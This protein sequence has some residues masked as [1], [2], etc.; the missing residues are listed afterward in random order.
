MK[1]IPKRSYLWHD[2]VEL[3]DLFHENTYTSLRH[4]KMPYLIDSII[5]KHK[6]NTIPI[7]VIRRRASSTFFH[8]HFTTNRLEII[9]VSITS[10]AD[11]TILYSFDFFGSACIEVIV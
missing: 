9:I 8:P 7:V 3:I 6:Q 1:V 4:G 11:L 2:N 5:W 10:P